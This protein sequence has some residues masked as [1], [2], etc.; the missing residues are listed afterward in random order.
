MPEQRVAK[1]TF[2][3]AE[4]LAALEEAEEQHGSMADAL[5]YA[6]AKTYVDGSEEDGDEPDTG[7]PVKAHEGHRKLMEWAGYRGR[8]E[9]GTAESV[10]ANHLNVQKEAVRKTVIEPLRKEDAI[11][12]H[13]GIH[14]V[15]IIVGTLE[16]D[17]PEPRDSTSTSTEAA[18]DGGE[19]RERL[20]E[21]ANAEVGR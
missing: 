14:T 11:R 17:E 20:D 18:T 21:L 13:Q 5:R 9:L 3:D 2:Y 6:V 15:S 4:L 7:L 12:I 8:L 1:A 19:A 10:L 16:G